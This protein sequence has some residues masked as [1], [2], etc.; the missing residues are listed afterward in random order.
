MEFH[1]AQFNTECIFVWYLTVAEATTAGA[2]SSIAAVVVVMLYFQQ[3]TMAPLEEK[4]FVIINKHIEA[5]LH[6][7]SYHP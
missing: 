3:N 2:L 6:S 1:R 7:V 5:L 4:H